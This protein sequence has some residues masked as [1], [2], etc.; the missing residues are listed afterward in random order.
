MAKRE[1]AEQYLREAKKDCLK[2]YQ[3]DW[4]ADKSYN[5]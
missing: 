5:I 1:Q 3:S 4:E 2:K